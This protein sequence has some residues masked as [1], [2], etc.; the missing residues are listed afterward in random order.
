MGAQML[1]DCSRLLFLGSADK[2]YLPYLKP[3]V[4]GVSCEVVLKD[5]I[6]PATL[7]ALCRAKGIN[8][9]ICSNVS[10]LKRLLHW[11]DNRKEP[12]LDNYQGSIFKREGLEILII[13]PLFHLTAVPYAKFVF[14]RFISKLVRRSSWLPAPDFHWS[15]LDARN[16]EAAY[17]NLQTAYAIAT[18]IETFSDPLSI[19]C[20]GF[21]GIFIRSGRIE[22]TSYVLPVDSLW[23]LAW[24]RKLV[25]LPAPKIF[26]NG[27]YDNAYLSMFRSPVYNW[28]W[29]TASLFHCWYSELPKDLA[30]LN[31]FCTRESMYWKDLAETN[32]LHEY[33]RYNA[34]DTWATANVWMAQMI[35][36][37]EYARQ[38][39][40]KEFPLNF[41]CHLS[42]MTG[43]K[44]DME[45]LA[46]ARKEADMELV[47]T[48]AAL[49]TMTATPGFNSNS[50]LQMKALMK[51]FGLGDVESCDETHLKRFALRHP[52]NSRIIN[53]ILDS[54]EIKKR[55]ST[56]L[57]TNDDIKKSGDRGAKEYRGRILYAINPHGTDSGRCASKESHFWCGLQIQNITRGPSIKR[58]LVADHG[59]RLAECDLEQAESRDT[60]YAAGELSLIAAVEGS[61]DFHSVNASAFFG[62][63]YENI[64]DDTRKKTLDKILRDLA[65]R[66]NHGA[67]YC[68]GPNVLVA[69]MG[70]DKV[71]EAKRLLRLPAKFGLK[72]VAEYLLAQFHKTYPGLSKVFYPKIWGDVK[73]TSMLVGATGW[74][75]FC[76]SDPTKDKHAANSYVAHVAQSLNAMT[77]N[78][79][80]MRV[81]YEIAMHPQ[82]RMHFKLCAQIHDSI[83]FQFREGHEYLVAMVKERMEIPVTIRGA[84]GVTR[85]FVVP[86]AAKAGPDGK[87]AF[88]WSETE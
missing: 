76:F 2:S 88:R 39:Y 57:R 84:D 24:M 83:L 13:N 32:D 41:P 48:Q 23:A 87:G 61:R 45:E 8:G 25:S 22:T 19:R 85:T 67:N 43:I 16:M 64:Y 49:E 60:A 35:E 73:T 44:R 20:I 55:N 74:T 56:Y 46:I 63:P 12:S 34:L 18:D 33:Y 9:V 66:V 86:A 80:Y 6:L 42:E 81:F 52:I 59:F 15:I 7:D 70:E 75:R 4:Q 58:T 78:Q 38:N 62:V 27:K 40:L 1:S 69:T 29:D 82:Y 68:M 53:K 5:D 10:F 28:L 21:T 50:P 17:A 26:Q 79:A 47:S 51:C 65:K 71:W 31:S 36:M 54:R 72:D 11:T 3:C 30:F 37:P 14:T 77:L